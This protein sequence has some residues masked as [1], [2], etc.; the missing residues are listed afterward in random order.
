MAN[1]PR[2]SSITQEPVPPGVTKSSNRTP[3]SAK[4]SPPGW[5][6]GPD[7]FFV[8]GSRA[9]ERVYLCN[10]LL[11]AFPS[12]GSASN[13]DA[14]AKSGSWRKAMPWP[15]RPSI[16]LRESW[17]D[18][19]GSRRK[20]PMAFRPRFAR[21]SIRGSTTSPPAMNRGVALIIDYGSSVTESFLPERADG[22][23]RGYRDHL[24]GYR[25]PGAPRRNRSHGGCQLHP[26]PDGGRSARLALSWLRG[27]GAISDRHRG[28][29]SRIRINSQLRC[30]A[31]SKHWS[32]PASR[33]AIRIPGIGK[34][35]GVGP[36][37]LPV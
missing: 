35:A 24:A 25:S 20:Q 3:A 10:E 22:S 12:G 18:G 28:G 1:F 4:S 8:A 29:P 11:D 33:A 2:T 26:S 16:S 14:G 15:K 7:C 23:V 13:G 19:P 27:S 31:N 37:W 32:T 34:L 36:R 9:A 17:T 30:G 5:G 21:R 6:S